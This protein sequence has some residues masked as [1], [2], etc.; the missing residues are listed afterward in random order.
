[1]CVCVCVCGGGGSL[2]VSQLL[3][4]LACVANLCIHGECED[5]LVCVQ[6][7]KGLNTEDKIDEYRMV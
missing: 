6:H 3:K 4:L 7:K 1:V 2:E 5:D